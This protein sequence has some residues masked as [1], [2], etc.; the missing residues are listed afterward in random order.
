MNSKPFLGVLGFALTSCTGYYH[1]AR[2]VAGNYERDVLVKVGG[3]SSQKGADGSSV[4][5]DD[6]AS[7]NDAATAAAGGYAA[8]QATK[9]RVSDNRLGQVQAQ[10]TTAQKANAIPPTVTTPTVD[11][12]TGQLLTPVVTPASTVVPAL[13]HH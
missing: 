13:P 3:T 9:A 12:A 8:G 6:Q 1:E 10:Q 11:P 4:V 2:S 5:T 7:F